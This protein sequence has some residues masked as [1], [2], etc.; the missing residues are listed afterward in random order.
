MRLI[1]SEIN[2]TVN[3]NTMQKAFFD[4]GILSEI[5]QTVNYNQLV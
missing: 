3:Y 4:N 1:L 2:Q 5:N